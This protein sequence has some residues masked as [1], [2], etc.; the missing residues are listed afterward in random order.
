VSLDAEVRISLDSFELVVDLTVENGEVVAVL[1]PNGSGK[2]TL[3]RALAGLAPLS[4]GH[5]ILDGLVLDSPTTRAFVAPERRHVGVVFQDYS[6]F[7]HLTA[8]ENVAFG[9]RCRGVSKVDARRRALE[10]LEGMDLAE[11]AG[12]RPG[13]LSGGQ[14][15]RVALARALATNPRMLLLDEPMAALDASTRP[16]MR[17]HLRRHLGAF[18]GPCVVV[19]HD[20]V[21]AAALA[22][23]LVIVEAGRVVQQ[24]TVRE[25]AAHPRTPFVA[26]LMG[27]NLVRGRAEGNRLVLDN[28]T[29]LQTASEATG[30]VFAVIAPRDVALYA[31][32]PGG[33]PRN[34]W[35]THVDEVHVLGQRVRVLL[36]GPVRI[37]AEVTTE[38][39]G[40]LGLVEGV[41]VWASVK[42]T[43]IDVYGA[44]G[45]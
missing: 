2:T 9:P 11:H 34:T 3:V 38:A 33:S 19:T 4:A 37:A 35:P 15:Q 43:Q 13:Q 26:E 8:L 14:A 28:G 5:V 30:D 40:E 18:D 7:S 41:P 21:D 17:H 22:D 20:P 23:R 1:G 27:L 12:V 31:S 45:D 25:V 44:D 10:L 6:L 36:G 32:P 24:G 42:A 16:S 39:I 29:E